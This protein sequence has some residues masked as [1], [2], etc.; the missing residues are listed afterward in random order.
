MHR[1]IQSVHP[2]VIVQ[3]I[4]VDDGS[5]FEYK[6]SLKS[7]SEANVPHLFLRHS[8]NIGKGQ[9]LRTA[10]SESEAEIIIYTDVDFPYNFESF[11]GLL[12][13]LLSDTAELVYGI[14]SKNYFDSIPSQ[15]RIISTV[16]KKMN[17][18]MFSLPS[19]DTQCG[20]KGFKSI[21]KKEFMATKAKRYMIDLEFL[22]RIAKHPVYELHPIEVTLHKD[23]ELGKMKLSTLFTE[24]REYLRILFTS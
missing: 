4:I 6:Q 22:Q 13:A 5:Q 17:Q 24:M 21:L 2:N 7:L 16:V 20:L 19:S 15:R 8:E 3:W 9:A 10:C 18:L 12:D 23:T 14:R 11:S 1:Q